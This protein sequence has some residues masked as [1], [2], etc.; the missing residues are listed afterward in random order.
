[1]KQITCIGIGMG[2][3]NT[4]TVAANTAIASCDLLIGATRM[5]SA[6][7]SV[8]CNTFASC[9]TDEICQYILDHPQYQNIG[10]LFSGDVGFYSGAKSFTQTCR[11]QPPF[12][13]YTITHICGISS[14][15]Y[16]C[17]KLLIPWEDV[18]IVSLHGR[19]TPWL[20]TI[21]THEKTFLLTGGTYSVENICKTLCEH[22]LQHVTVHVGSNLSYQ[23]E[24]IICGS[25]KELAEKIYPT[26]SVVLIE[27]SESK[28]NQIVTHG[29]PDQ[30]FA[31]GDVP[32]TKSEVRSISLSKLQLTNQDIVYDIGAG[33][34]SVAIELALQLPKGTVYAIEK[35][36]EAIALLE[37]NKANFGAYNMQIING[38]AP[39]ALQPLPAPSKAFIG[40]SS[41]NMKEIL[42]CLLGKNPQVRIVINAIA[43]ETLTESITLLKE[44]QVPILDVT[45]ACIAK[46]K[47]VGNYH[48]MM[49]QNPV[50]IITAQRS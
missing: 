34:G 7:S 15:V 4:L 33:T 37:Q 23:D 27:N 45:Q 11:Q 43:L 47:Q 24:S 36:P 12:N 1:M 22:Q 49:G 26:L 13:D 46:A 28:T 50:F 38:I 2:N 5:L 19:E 44:L 40:G 31:R 48:M 32:M 39:A 3:P 18:A 30:A 10:I 9:K 20:N 14:L 16:F 42:S 8:S 6:F 41:G 25:P 17:S 21:M 35:N 29:L